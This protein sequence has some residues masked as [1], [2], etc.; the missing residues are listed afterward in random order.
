MLF[1]FLLF[2]LL[3][4]YLDNVIQQQY[5]TSKHPLYFLSRSYWNIG[6]RLDRLG[7][8]P[9]D[10]E[11]GYKPQEAEDYYINKRN[12]EAVNNPELIA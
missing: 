5:G 7:I 1:S 12:Y 11:K 8:K 10:S 6:N 3:G 2:S 4:L 9:N